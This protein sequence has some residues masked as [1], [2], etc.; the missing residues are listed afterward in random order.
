MI[1]TRKERIIYE[2]RV[3]HFSLIEHLF[4]FNYFS[5]YMFQPEIN[6]NDGGHVSLHVFACACAHACTLGLLDVLVLVHFKGEA[7]E[8]ST[9]WW[10][11]GECGGAVARRGGV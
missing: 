2:L 9:E 3:F 4:L 10:G 1:I 7:D 11:E 6:E 8:T 5:S